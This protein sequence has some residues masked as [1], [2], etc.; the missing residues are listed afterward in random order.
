MATKKAKSKSYNDM[1]KIREID[2]WIVY[3]QLRFRDGFQSYRPH[4]MLEEYAKGYAPSVLRSTSKERS[5][6]FTEEYADSE[7]LYDRYGHRVT[8]DDLKS[9]K[10]R[11]I[12]VSLPAST[13]YRKGLKISEKTLNLYKGRRAMSDIGEHLYYQ[14]MDKLVRHIHSK[15]KSRHPLERRSSR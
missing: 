13:F 3:P 14:E 5:D 4:I 8:S 7:K 9:K 15:R 12:I 11:R 2:S 6:W 1:S 10:Q